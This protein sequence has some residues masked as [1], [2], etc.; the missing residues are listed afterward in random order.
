MVARAGGCYERPLKTKLGVN[1]GYPVSLT[2]FNIVV[3]A[4]VWATLMEVCGPQEAQ[5]G[6]G[7]AAGDQ[8]TVFCA[9]N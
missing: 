5:N 3:D 9:N 6:L 8:D 4:V 2:I 7:W 1:Q